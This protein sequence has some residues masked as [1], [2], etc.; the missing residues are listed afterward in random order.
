MVND[1]PNAAYQ[2]MLQQATTSQIEVGKFLTV[3][4]YA[5]FVGPGVIWYQIW[6][7]AEIPNNIEI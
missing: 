6:H 1:N 5:H 2:P 3:V 7:F 4:P